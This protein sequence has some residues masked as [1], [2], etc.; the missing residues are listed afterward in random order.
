MVVVEVSA[1]VVVVVVSSNSVVV[2]LGRV[3]VVVE[4]GLVVVVVPSSSPT[5]V[6]V[7]DGVV[8]VVVGSSRSSPVISTLSMYTWPVL[9]T[10]VTR[11]RT[12]ND[13]AVKSEMSNSGWISASL[14][15]SYSSMVTHPPPCVHL[16]SQGASQLEARN[17]VEVEA[18]LGVLEDSGVR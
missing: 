12:W 11:K 16:D 7:V 15:R 1:T 4:R 9:R 8:V 14:P 2:V 5:V 17:Y 6:V 13:S 18:E 3:V 10:P